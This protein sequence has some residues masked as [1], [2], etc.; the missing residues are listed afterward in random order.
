MNEESTD[1]KLMY[2]IPFQEVAILQSLLETLENQFSETVYIDIE[3][4]TLEDAYINIAKKEEQLLE[5]LKN[6]G[7]RRQSEIERNSNNKSNKVGN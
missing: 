7:A 6:G 4:N 2:Q 5:D 1:K 3:I